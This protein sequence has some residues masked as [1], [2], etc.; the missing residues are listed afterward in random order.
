MGTGDEGTQRDLRT[1]LS[2]VSGKE[3][4]PQAHSL[5][6]AIERHRKWL[7]WAWEREATPEAYAG[8]A[9]VYEHPDFVTRFDKAGEGFTTYLT[10]AMRS[11]AKRPESN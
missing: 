8:L 4:P 2:R 7:T 1:K 10:T 3:L 11:W 5:D 9:D 6:A